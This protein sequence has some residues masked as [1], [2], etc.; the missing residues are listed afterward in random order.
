M[1]TDPTRISSL[2]AGIRAEELDKVN[3]YLLNVQ[4]ISWYAVQSLQGEDSNA[5]QDLEFS[6]FETFLLYQRV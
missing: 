1:K 3:S 5:V 4:Q 6:V 2:T